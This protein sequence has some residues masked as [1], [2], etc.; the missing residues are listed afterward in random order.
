M[1]LAKNARIH[2]V[3]CNPNPK[4]FCRSCVAWKIAIFLNARA[5][6]TVSQPVNAHTLYLCCVM[7]FRPTLVHKPTRLNCDSIESC[8]CPCLRV[9]QA[10]VCAFW[11]LMRRRRRLP[12]LNFCFFTVCVT[13]ALSLSLG[14]HWCDCVPL[15]HPLHP[16]QR[17]G[18]PLTHLRLGSPAASPPLLHSLAP[19]PLAL[20]PPPP[21]PLASVS[22]SLHSSFI[23]PLSLH[24]R[25]LQ[26]H[27]PP[28][29]S[30]EASPKSLA[31]RTKP[32]Y[33]LLTSRQCWP[34]SPGAKTSSATHS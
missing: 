32:P 3:H 20:L 17:I 29:L 27:T 15:P 19:A 25:C 23:Q 34:S 9:T 4:R 2:A 6:R 10:C 24:A 22:P 31:R 33:H 7:C 18:H 5:A 14:C 1:L 26:C 13:L 30:L 21:T 11:L 8:V 16:P 12:D 28:H